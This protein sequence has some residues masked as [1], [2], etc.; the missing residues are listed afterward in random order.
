MPLKSLD[1][2]KNFVGHE[3]GVTDWFEITQERIFN[4][5]EATEDR[6]WIHLDPARARLESP[7]GA[8]V[9]HGFL[10][11]SLLSHLSEQALQIQSGVGMIVNYGLNRVR[12]PAPVRS[13]SRIRARFT[14]QSFKT[15]DNAREATFSVVVEVQDQPKPCCVADWVVR[16]YPGEISLQP[17]SGVRM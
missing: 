6:Q 10:T 1:E 4:F 12:F 14:L 11:L 2:L 16:F 3:I 15:P 8:T 9:A 5:A 13:G 17:Q 7:Y